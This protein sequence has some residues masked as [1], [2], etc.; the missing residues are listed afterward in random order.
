MCS[1]ATDGSDGAKQQQSWRHT[2]RGGTC[3]QVT[4]PASSC[5]AVSWRALTPVDNVVCRQF[6]PIMWL[7]LQ[8]DN[9]FQFNISNAGHLL[10]PWM[11]VCKTVCFVSNLF[12][13]LTVKSNNSH[14]QC[15]PTIRL[16]AHSTAIFV[17]VLSISSMKQKTLQ[18]FLNDVV[19]QK[20]LS[21]DSSRFHARGAA[22][23]KAPSLIFRPVL[24]TTK[25][26]L[27]MNAA[28]TV[29]EC[30]RRASTCRLA[31]RRLS[32][33][34]LCTSRLYSLCDR[35][36]MQL[37]QSWSDMVDSVEG[38]V[39]SPA[40]PQEQRCSG[41]GAARQHES[42][43]QLGSDVAAELTT[44]WTYAAQMKEARLWHTRDVLAHWQL[45]VEHDA[46]STGDWRRLDDV[47][48]YGDGWTDGRQLTEL[49]WWT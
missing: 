23:V 3:P 22:T 37:P 10:L 30:Q 40:N 46:Q 45:G 32:D 36:P 13:N 1:V 12:F 19:E 20:S 33:E 49:W 38:L 21:S 5:T 34:H 42:C 27:S 41:Q 28:M 25:S 48:L 18:L 2:H 43:N 16:M 47:P 24:G 7:I 26:Q 44:D 17:S 9:S 39:S 31:I 29:K 4:I 14:L 8:F 35:Q 15:A 11:N 6:E